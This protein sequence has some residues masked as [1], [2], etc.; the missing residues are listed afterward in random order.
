MTTRQV[1]SE[2]ASTGV[3]GL[4]VI[5]GGGLFAN[6]VYMVTGRHGAGKTILS[7]QLA[8]AHVRS[9]GR[10]V[11]T[12]L[13]SDETRELFIREVEVPTQNVSAI[14]HNILFMRQVEVDATLM[15]LLS[16]MK[17]RDSAAD[18]RLWHY[19]IGGRGV[20]L[21]A[22]FDPVDKGLMTGGHGKGR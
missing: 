4:D 16:V 10:V 17:T 9:G 15:R 7:N 14:F 8:F 22:P 20:E 13:I 5:L 19:E 2:R 21:L 12:T 3:H 11:Y 18:R 6:A 1:E